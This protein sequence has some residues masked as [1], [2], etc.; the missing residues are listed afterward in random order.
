MKRQSE[1][2]MRRSRKK[3][4]V[5]SP[6]S[7]HECLMTS[8]SPLQ[9]SHSSTHRACAAS[10]QPLSFANRHRWHKMPTKDVIPYRSQM[11]KED[12]LCSI[13]NRWCTYCSCD[14][15]SYRGMQ[16]AQIQHTNT[17][18]ACSWLSLRMAW[19][20]IIKIKTSGRWYCSCWIITQAYELEN[21]TDVDAIS[22]LCIINIFYQQG[23]HILIDLMGWLIK[24]KSHS[25][26]YCNDI[27]TGFSVI[28][29]MLYIATIK[30]KSHFISYKDR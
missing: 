12:D 24:I 16:S 29:N 19:E 11:C 30:N 15:S 23:I 2:E 10:G 7:Q 4:G 18:A 26:L 13:N 21:V 5:D 17:Q 28:D 27:H 25:N 14:V 9:T 3:H 1:R 6:H 20:F 22:L 8:Y